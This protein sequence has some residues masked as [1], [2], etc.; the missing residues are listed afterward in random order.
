MLLRWEAWAV[1]PSFDIAQ[2][3]LAEI[4]FMRFL[5]VASL[6]AL[7]ALTA[8]SEQAMLPDTLMFPP[9]LNVEYLGQP[10]KL[11]G[12]SQCAQ[13]Q[14]TGHTCLIFPPQSPRSKGVIISG[15]EMYEVQLKAKIDPKDPT[16]YLIVDA[17]GRVILRTN[18]RHDEYG[19]IEL[20]P[21]LVE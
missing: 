8:C 17:S 3:D 21:L 13:G 4:K 6:S 16:H 10:G 14:L 5:K 15:S 11:Y 18:G 12:T 1:G 19:N 20:A 2:C 7:L 9:G